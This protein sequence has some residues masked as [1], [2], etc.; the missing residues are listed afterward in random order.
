MYEVRF[1]VGSVVLYAD[2]THINVDVYENSVLVRRY[3]GE[4]P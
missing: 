2:E 1:K 3:S 4:F